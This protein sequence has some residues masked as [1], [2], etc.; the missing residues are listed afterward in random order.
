MRDVWLHQRL[1]KVVV[2]EFSAVLAPVVQSMET[3]EREFHPADVQ[4]SYPLEF[5]QRCNFQL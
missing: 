4:H 2:L 1:G 3:S 5:G